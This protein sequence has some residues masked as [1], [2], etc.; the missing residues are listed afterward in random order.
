MVQNR[1]RKLLTRLRIAGLIVVALM[2]ASLLYL[3]RLYVGPSAAA[4]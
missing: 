3:A 4:P 2:F 1:E